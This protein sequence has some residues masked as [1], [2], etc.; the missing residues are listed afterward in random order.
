M[1]YA[2]QYISLQ[3]P[4]ARFEVQVASYLSHLIILGQPVHEL[5][6]ML[7]SMIL[8]IQYIN[9]YTYVQIQFHTI[10]MTQTFAAFNIN[11]PSATGY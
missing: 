5:G 4:L 9:I 7:C 10:K 11:R 1:E 2:V 6:K 3:V 8:Q